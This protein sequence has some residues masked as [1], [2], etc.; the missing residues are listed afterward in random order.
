[1]KAMG[2]PTTPFNH[3]KDVSVHVASV[4]LANTTKGYLTKVSA[5]EIKTRRVAAYRYLLP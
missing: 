4:R 1:M 5:E 3:K 2:K